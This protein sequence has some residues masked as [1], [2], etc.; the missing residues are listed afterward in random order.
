MVATV[1]D[2]LRAVFKNRV[3]L[4]GDLE[5]LEPEIIYQSGLLDCI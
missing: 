3:S 4:G 1:M 2:N 5:L